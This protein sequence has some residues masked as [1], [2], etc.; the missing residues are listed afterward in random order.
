V[1]DILAA[2][3]SLVT[4]LSGDPVTTG[5]VKVRKFPKPA[6]RNSTPVLFVEDRDGIYHEVVID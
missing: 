1:E 2:G 3:V 5:T 4:T 6:I